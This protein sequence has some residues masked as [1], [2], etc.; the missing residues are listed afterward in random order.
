MK[1]K[2]IAY[3]AI[4]VE[5][6][7]IFLFEDLSYFSAEEVRL[8]CDDKAL[9][10]ELGNNIVSLTDRI[11]DKLLKNRTIFL[12]KS[13]RYSYDLNVPLIALKIEAALLDKLKAT[14]ENSTIDLVIHK[15]QK[16]K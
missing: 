5:D 7:I 4:F 1:G 13:P 10:I 3:K 14:R 9:F 11:I 8:R 12:Y 6:G 16:F 15:I 2:N